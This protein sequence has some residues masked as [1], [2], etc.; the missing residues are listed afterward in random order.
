M[1]LLTTNQ[2]NQGISK[3]KLLSSNAGVGS[4]ITTKLGYYILVSDITKWDF[5]IEA[6]KVLDEVRREEIDSSK[7]YEKAKFRIPNRGIAVVDDKRFVEFLKTEKELTEL[8][9]LIGIP[10]ISLNEQFNSPNWKTH[11]IYKFLGEKAKAEHFMVKGTHFPKWF[12]N[13]KGE[14]KQYVEWKKIWNDNKLRSENFVPPRDANSPIK[15]QS[16]KEVFKTLKDQDGI[17]HTI[18]LYKELSQ[19]NLILVCPNGHL[20]DIPWAKFLKWKSEKKERNDEGKNLFSIDKCCPTPNLLWTESKTK[21][22]GYASIYLEC[23]S[24]GTGSGKDNKQKITLEGINNLKP[25]C[26]GQKPWEI[27]LGQDSGVNIHTEDCYKGGD[28]SRGPEFMQLALVTGN[29]V[30]YA[31]SFSSLYIPQHLAENRSKE[32]ADAIVKCKEKFE[33]YSRV[34][35]EITKEAFWEQLDKED[36]IIDNNY[37]VEDADEFIS[38]LREEFLESDSQDTTDDKYEAFRW[39]EYRCFSE[40]KSIEE[41]GLRFNDIKIPTPLKGYFDKIQ[42][43]SELRLTQVQLDFTRVRPRERIKIEDKVYTS[44]AGKN[45]FSCERNALFVMPAN[46]TLGE[47]LFFKFS[48][49]KIKIWS[50]L[51]SQVAAERFKNFFGTVDL[52]TQGSS[53][54]QRIKNNGFKHFL[55]HTFSHLL[56][57]ELEFS[58]GYPTA[59]L[60]ERLYISDRMSGV[61][62]YT[63]EGS[64]GSMGGLVWQGHPERITHLIARALE[65]SFDCSSDPLCWESEG[66][67]IFELNLAACFACSLVS[68]TACEEQNLGLDRRALIDTQFGFFKD[69]VYPSLLQLTHDLVIQ[70]FGRNAKWSKINERFLSTVENSESKSVG[71]DEMIEMSDRNEFELEDVFSVVGLLSTPGKDVL[72]MEFFTLNNERLKNDIVYSKLRQFWKEKSISKQEWEEWAS[73]IVV[74]WKLSNS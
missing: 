64:E 31:N 51:L 36:F 56:M 43:V 70:N 67:G 20:S 61:L 30:Y 26:P 3:Y 38:L 37:E 32:L 29:N 12:R 57:R 73:Q 60:K 69:G 14:L 62:I 7:R 54:R 5:V 27:D 19:T 1:N 8:V 58:C 50:E 9:C 28:K 23:R 49:D 21:S 42:Q 47:G 35:K 11:P 4:I 45:I 44:A 40:K 34:K 52:R 16:G 65:R 74:K 72:R 15:D 10:S 59:S 22:E 68:E 53:T 39:Q 13:E 71:L 48:D 6:Q 66:Q 18:K 17:S 25:C 33:R 46:E 41:K 55:I 63:A 24:C 2:Y